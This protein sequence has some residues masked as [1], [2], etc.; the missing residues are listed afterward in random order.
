MAKTPEERGLMG[1]DMLAT[2]R[3]MVAG[4]IPADSRRTAAG[5][6]FATAF[7]APCALSV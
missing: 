1:F 3:A 6:N 5:R 2:A 7:M 4:S